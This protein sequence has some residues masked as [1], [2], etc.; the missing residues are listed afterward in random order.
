MHREMNTPAT[1]SQSAKQDRTDPILAADAPDGRRE[2]LAVVMRAYNETAENLC[3]THDSLRGQVLRLQQELVSTNAQ[4]QRSKRLAA[5]G[6]MATGIAHEVR[7]PLAAIQLYADMLAQD[8]AGRWQGD[9][10]PLAI[11]A[12]KIVAA[13]RGLDGVVTDVLSF[14]QEILPE[15]N[16]VS[17]PGLFDDALLACQPEIDADGIEV[18]RVGD[19]AH[20]DESPATLFADAALMQR[21][22]INLIR[23][24]IEAMAVGGAHSGDPTMRRPPR[25]LT[26]SATR[27]GGCVTLSI[28][29]TGAGIADKDVDRIFNPFFT[30]RNTGTGLGLAIVHR[31]IDAHGG[32]I[33]AHNDGG[34]VFEL[35]LA[36]DESTVAS[37]PVSTIAPIGRYTPAVA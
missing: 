23:N 16:W 15:R 2:E 4:L 14:A 22:L 32:T 24:A 17:V 25:R 12:R 34:A 9:T 21:A 11:T 26:C 18:R 19:A 33:S 30:T 20:H 27:T 37:S 13:V 3:R 31:I 1:P 36:G 7:N 28:R 5:L 29:D 35:N 6:E 10:A 8:L